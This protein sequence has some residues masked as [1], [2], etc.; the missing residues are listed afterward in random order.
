MFRSATRHGV[1][2]LSNV[3]D[4]ADSFFMCQRVRQWSRRVSYARVMRAKPWLRWTEKH[5]SAPSLK[6]AKAAE[7]PG[8]VKTLYNLTKEAAGQPRIKPIPSIT[9]DDNTTMTMGSVQTNER[10]RQ[11]FVKLLQGRVTTLAD[12]RTRS[13]RRHQRA[14]SCLKD[15]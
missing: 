12:F 6:Q 11:N 3:Q 8:N 1:V 5:T 7:Y 9:M 15:V 10:W 14:G 13:I 4:A 2:D